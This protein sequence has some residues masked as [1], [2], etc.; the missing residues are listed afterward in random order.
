MQVAAVGS[1]RAVA[2]REAMLGLY[3]HGVTEE[4]AR[5]FLTRDDVPLLIELLR[6]PSFPRRDNVAAFLAML[7]EGSATADL[8]SFLVAPPVDVDVPEELRAMLVAP[9]ALGRIAARGDMRALDALLAIT[10]DG[11][12]GGPFLAGAQRSRQVGRADDVLESALRGLALSGADEGRRRLEEIARGSVRPRSHG[13]DMGSA[14]SRELDYFETLHPRRGRPGPRAGSVTGSD[15]G[16]SIA[17]TAPPATGNVMD[18]SSVTNGAALTYA[19]HTAVPNKMNDARLDL[20]LRESELRAG[21]ED[22]AA[23]AMCCITVDRSGTAQ[24]LTGAGLDV[25]DNGTELNQVL[26]NGISRVKVVNGINWCDGPGMNILG[27]A[28]I[29]AIGMSLVRM[30]SINDEA[31]LWLH[32]YG[33]NVGLLHSGS[34]EYIMFGFLSSGANGITPAQCDAYHSPGDGSSPPVTGICADSDGDKIHDLAD[35]CRFLANPTQLDTDFDGQGD[36]CDG[37]A[38]SDGVADA[39]DCQPLDLNVWAVPGEATGLMLT[40]GGMGTILGWNPP[41]APG[42]TPS[43]P[44]YDVLRAVGALSFNANPL[45][46]ESDGG[47]DTV[48]TTSL[49]PTTLWSGEGSGLNFRY[50]ASVSTAGNINNDAYDDIIVGS[51][52]YNDGGTDLEGRIEVRFGSAGGPGGLWSYDSDVDFATLGTSVSGGG[53][54]DNDGFDD[55][56]AGAP[57]FDI[58]PLFGGAA[59]A[60]YGS[61][62]GL[63]SSPDWSVSG[64]TSGMS[65]GSAVAVA[66]D[67]DNDNYDDVIVGAPQRTVGFAGEGGAFLYRGSA[68]GLLATPTS[69]MPVG[70]ATGVRFGASVASA[71]DVNNDGFDDVIVGAPNAASGQATEGLAYVYHGS[72]TG[73]SASPDQTLQVNQLAAAFGWSVASAGDINNDGYDDVIVGAKEYDVDQTNEGAAFIFYGSATG[74]D[75]A[76]GAPLHGDKGNADYGISVSSAGDYN[77][78][79]YDDVVVGASTTNNGL[80]RAG[81][82]YLYL[83]SPFG[84]VPFQVM[85]G[86]QVDAEF[87]VAVARGGDTDGDNLDDFVAASH[88]FDDG[89][90]NEGLARVNAGTPGPDPPVGSIHY[91]LV[92][93]QNPCGTGPV[94]FTSSGS[95]IS[96]PDCTPAE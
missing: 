42:G 15:P 78:D 13:R 86:E 43:S 54:F 96:A 94:G 9:Q 89:Q 11:S 48:A 93:A 36:P 33:H 32:E 82:V 83:G 56:I 68:S 23:D 79:G 58:E 51:P 62:S 24:A 40:H 80:T 12:E 35:N 91:F 1:E 26:N 3:V 6:D 29:G 59:F 44:R 88:L 84:L 92:R 52:G 7:D 34:A 74:I 10:R 45:C 85:E 41:A 50:G 63:P 67:V 14:A 75:P 16:S 60:F 61:A 76:I 20:V 27:C 19:N 2:V 73:L 49:P 66:G 21:R 39:S 31:V 71:G 81:R 95:A 77:G 70:G 18:T 65:F 57:S 55:I 38:D 53:D 72:P 17:A 30:T 47:P 90:T 28:W 25:I 5:A 8:L 4:L 64:G 46:L 69:W 37:D 22:F 87:G